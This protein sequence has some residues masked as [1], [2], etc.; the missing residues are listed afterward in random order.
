[1]LGAIY[2]QEKSILKGRNIDFSG[3]IGGWFGDRNICL[4][5]SFCQIL[6][7]WGQGIIFIGAYYNL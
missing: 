3:Q 2:T 6:S 5:I 1:M 4:D 7:S